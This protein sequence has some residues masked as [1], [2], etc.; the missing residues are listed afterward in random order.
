MRDAATLAMLA[1]D[2]PELA[3]LPPFERPPDVG[4]AVAKVGRPDVLDWYAGVLAVRF[5]RHVGRREALDAALLLAR[6]V[7]AKGIAV[8]GTAVV[9]AVA[10]RVGRP[11]A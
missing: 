4:S 8:A 3:D 11:P 6:F 5:G 7:E 9:N 10:D 2:R 1:R